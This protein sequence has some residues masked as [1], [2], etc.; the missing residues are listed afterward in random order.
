MWHCRRAGKHAAYKWKLIPEQ[1]FPDTT[2]GSPHAVLVYSW[3]RALRTCCWQVTATWWAQIFQECDLSQAMGNRRAVLVYSPFLL[4][5]QTERLDMTSA[6]WALRW[7]WEER[8]TGVR[9]WR[10]ASREVVG[11]GAVSRPLPPELGVTTVISR[12]ERTVGFHLYFNFLYF[13][14]F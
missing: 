5:K 3:A 2:S 4:P 1:H 14:N 10:K 7:C 9:F 8:P 12:W 11:T 13:P 6:R